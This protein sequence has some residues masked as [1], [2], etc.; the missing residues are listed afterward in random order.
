M[1]RRSLLPPVAT[2]VLLAA[3]S[4][5]TR[6]AGPTPSSPDAPVPGA[7]ILGIPGID[8]A[9]QEFLAAEAED[10]RAAAEADSVAADSAAAGSPV[11]PSDFDLPIHYNE[12]VRFW[13]D[14][15]RDRHRDRFARALARM[16]RYAP[17]IRE[18]LRERGMPEDLVYLALI[19]SGFNPVARSRAAAVG[20]WQFIAET[21]RRYG[22][23]IDRY[24]DERRDPFR[25]TDAALDYLQTLYDRFGS[26]YLAA[27]AYN[28]GEGRLERLLQ[29][30]AGGQ[31][32]ADSL[33]WRID[34]YLPKETRH[35]VPKLIAVTI[36][37]RYPEPFGFGEVAAEAPEPFDVVSVPDATDLTVIAE[38]AGV[39]VQTIKRL[40]PHF[41][42]G[43]T[44]PG[45]AVEV[46]VPAG[47]GPAFLAAYAE[48]PPGR[49]VRALEHTVRRGETL[50]E[51]AR[52]YGTTVAELQALN[53]IR[54]P[55]TVRAGR[56]LI[57]RL[58]TGGRRTT[59]Y[60]VRPGDSLWS[61]ARRHGTTVQRLLEWN[62]LEEDAILRP[63]D[64]VKVRVSR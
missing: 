56:R 57:V 28:S 1:G 33:F 21:G 13:M 37:A 44:P 60:T 41:I 17:Y 42:R 62:D 50:S 59:V 2:L 23:R 27:A 48:I 32:G 10:A 46:R 8:A 51:I 24:V 5:A 58:S 15:Y 6:P 34:Q 64:R 31:R 47:R 35:Y 9:N 16:G 54:D 38:A 49:R 43:V 11:D 3:C 52:R 14:Y 40:N 22:L 19:E 45:R 61:I 20:I 36:L 7:D 63:G 26:W 12:R 18:K 30:H 25:S 39:D 4:G 55:H 53:G 29:R